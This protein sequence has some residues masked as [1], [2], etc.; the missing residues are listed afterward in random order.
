MRRSVRGSRDTYLKDRAAGNRDG[1]SLQGRLRARRCRATCTRG[2]R[3]PAPTACPEVP[4]HARTGS[5]RRRRGRSGP[6][7]P[8]PAR[9]KRHLT[10]DAVTGHHV[11]RAVAVRQAQEVGL[12]DPVWDPDDL[13]QLILVIATYWA[14]ASGS[15]AE[16]PSRAT[17]PWQRRSS[18]AS[19]SQDGDVRGGWIS[20]HRH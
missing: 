8:T 14:S 5:R 11:E 9:R 15:S 17:G 2:H 13:L 20:S 10:L 6:E 4:P 18:D 19:S 12:V 3:R 1:A 16:S 7:H